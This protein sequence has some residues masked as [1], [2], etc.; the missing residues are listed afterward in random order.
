MRMKKL[1]EI[2]VGGVWLTG[3]KVGGRVHIEW[4]K[5]KSRK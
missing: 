2:E 4:R 3:A 5:R 1:E